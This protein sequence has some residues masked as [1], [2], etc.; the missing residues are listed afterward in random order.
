MVKKDTSHIKTSHFLWPWTIIYIN[1]IYIYIFLS[2]NILKTIASG[3]QYLQNHISFTTI[4]KVEVCLWFVLGERT[5]PLENYPNQKHV[6]W[7]W[8]PQKNKPWSDSKESKW[9]AN[10]CASWVGKIYSY[11]R[12]VWPEAPKGL[13]WWRGYGR[14]TQFERPHDQ[15]GGQWDFESQKTCVYIFNKDTG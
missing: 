7:G 9:L 10:G 12:E 3:V 14:E 4:F 15:W 6:F 5:K 13:V 2:K 1:I 11:L 8:H